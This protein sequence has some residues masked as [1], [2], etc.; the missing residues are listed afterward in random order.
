MA[1]TKKRKLT[2]EF[3]SDGITQPESL[4]LPPFVQKGNPFDEYVDIYEVSSG[5]FSSVY[6]ASSRSGDNKKAIKVLNAGHNRTDKI[7]KALKEAKI[8]L[9]IKHLNILSIDEVWYDGT[10]FFFVMK[11]ITPISISSLPKSLKEKIVLFQQLV[12]A[13]AHLHS[14]GIL[15]RDIKVQNTGIILDGTQK[16]VL[17]DFGEA[18]EISD[19]CHQCVGTALHMS[20]EV[21]KFYQYSDR[22]EIWALMSF[23]IEILT[24]KPMILHLFDGLLGSISAL[25]VQLKIDSL[26]EPPIP[27]VFKIDKTPYGKL[28]LQILEKGLTIAPEERLTFPELELFLQELIALL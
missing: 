14:I 13:A 5:A 10:R 19:H 16:L 1:A 17:F 18:C 25:Y 4:D 2:L 12:L 27:A 24:G 28:L 7:L 11:L 15:H 21:L 26:S 3:P 22:S 6:Q 20:P 9:Q 23:L 8:G